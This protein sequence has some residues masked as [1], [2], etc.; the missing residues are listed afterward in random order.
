MKV[1]NTNNEE[2]LLRSFG[3]YRI[4]SSGSAQIDIKE[5]M[6]EEI[7]NIEIVGTEIIIRENF[8]EEG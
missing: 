3:P 1:Y 2:G 4:L 8:E 7:G 5:Q 6:I